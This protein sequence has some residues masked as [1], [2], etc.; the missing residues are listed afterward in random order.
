MPLQSYMKLISV[1]D[2]VIEHPSV[3]E[4]RLPPAMRDRGPR[5]VEV[6]EEFRG[7]WGETFAPG[8]QLWVYEDRPNPQLALNAVAGKPYEERNLEPRRYDELMPGCYDPVARVRDMD[9]DGVHAQLCFPNVPRFAGTLFLQSDDLQLAQV[10]VEAYNDFILDE[11]C[12]AA[13]GRLIPLIILPLWDVDLAANEVRRCAAKGAKAISFPENTVPLGLPSFWTDHWDTLFDVV[14]DTDLALCMHFGTSGSVPTTSPEAPEIVQISLMGTNSM[15]AVVD[16]LFSPL[17]H[18]HPALRIMLSEGGI[19]WMPYLLERMDSSWE[20]NRSYMP[21]NQ[22][23]RP[24]ELFG[25]HIWGCFIDDPSGIR[26]RDQI[27]I[28]RILWEGDYPHSDSNFPHSRKIL[29]EALADVPD[30]DAHRMVELN[31]RNVLRL[32]PDPS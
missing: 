20:R 4:T 2:H 5:V 15:F 25:R 21:I 18:N 10:C 1:D 24:S 30:E 12:A 14:E 3:W 8:S 32:A 6:K 27:G 17:L 16:I 22:E 26:A 19:G 29:G 23:V 9:L 28:D 31:A 13:P 11:W 7:R